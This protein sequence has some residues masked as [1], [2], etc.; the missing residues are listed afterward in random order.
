MALRRYLRLRLHVSTALHERAARAPVVIGIHPHGCAA[1]YRVAMDGML[2]EALPGRKI[3]VLA[4]SVLFALPLVR[5]GSQGVVVAGEDVEV[6][7]LLLLAQCRRRGAQR[8]HPH[9]D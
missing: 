6:E 2:Y 5:D 9:G 7:R 3:V 1:D 8:R 4:A